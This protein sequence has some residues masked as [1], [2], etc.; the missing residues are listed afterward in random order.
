M[1]S[2]LTARTTHL[3]CPDRSA[4]AKRPWC[5]LLPLLACVG[6]LGC[7]TTRWTDTQRSL[8]E[9]WLVSSAIDEAVSRIDFSVLRDKTVFL[10]SQYLDLLVVDKGYLISSVRQVLLASGCLLQEDRA[11]ATY[12]VELRSGGIG[13]DRHDVLVG[14]PQMSIPTFYLTQGLPAQTPE[15]AVAKSTKQ[16]GG[17]KIEVFAYNRATGQPVWQSGIAQHKTLTKHRWLMGIGPFQSGTILS[18]T[19]LAGEPIPIPF[20]GEKD[21]DTLTDQ[22]VV[23]VSHEAIWNRPGERPRA[24]SSLSAPQAMPEISTL[25]RL[26]TLV[27][28]E[29][30]LPESPVLSVPTIGSSLR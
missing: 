24:L 22:S 26:E 4:P 30:N 17:A 23:P 12:I 10:D 2:R 6:T 18:G 27:E 25:P 3:D 1:H 7:G 21:P 8:T 11:K 29:S 9:Q 5:V 20:F 15:L 14:L 28:D 16:I 19:S 13:T